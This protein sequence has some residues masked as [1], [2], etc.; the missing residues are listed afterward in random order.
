MGVSLLQPWASLTAWLV[1]HL[2]TR[3]WSTKYRGRLAIAASGRWEA[4]AIDEAHENDA[5]LRVF[6]THGIRT[7]KE[8]PLGAIVAVTTLV[9]VLPTEWVLSID[10]QRGDEPLV[11]EGVDCHPDELR[12]GNYLPGRYAWVL[13]DT[14]ALPQPIPIK[15]ALNI[16]PIVGNPADELARE[17]AKIDAVVRRPRTPELS[18]MIPCRLQSTYDEGAA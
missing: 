14:I 7:L 17:V 6:A 8:L 3:S 9:A 2:E 12:F 11:V 13:K 1:K 16:W 10:A 18:P 4:E 15:G 5:M